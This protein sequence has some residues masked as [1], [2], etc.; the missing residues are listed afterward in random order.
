MTTTRTEFEAAYLCR[1]DADDFAWAYNSARA[2][3]PRIGDNSSPFTPCDEENTLYWTSADGLSGFAIRESGE[4]VN[5]FSLVPGR[6]DAIV[7]AAVD[8]GADCLDCFDGF[9]PAFYARHG[10]VETARQ[11]NWTPGGPDVV[12]MSR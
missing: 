1:V 11:P 10:F 2:E 4:L 7:T 8:R 12:W 3:S 9:L 6:G 5:V